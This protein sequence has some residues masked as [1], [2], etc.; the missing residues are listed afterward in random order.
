MSESR[1]TVAEFEG[2]VAEA[3]PF[4][5]DYGFRVESLTRGR[6]VVRLPASDR[7][8]RPGGTVSGPA[9]MAL[10]DFTMYAVTLSEVGRVLLAVTTSLNINFLRRPKPGDVVAEGRTLKA[11]RRLVVLEVDVFSDGVE[12]PVAHVTGTYSVPPEETEAT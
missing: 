3:A 8:L 2:L 11:G 7:H 12:E 4:A 6:A 9:M 10:A 5:A 1:I